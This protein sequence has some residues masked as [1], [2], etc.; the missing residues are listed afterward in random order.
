MIIR[1]PTS[2]KVVSTVGFLSTGTLSVAAFS[3]D[4]KTIAISGIS[5]IE[6]ADTVYVFDVATGNE[7]RSFK[8]YAGRVCALAFSPDGKRL[9]TGS[10]DSTA[11]VWDLSAKP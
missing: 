4:G 11:L 2:G 3:M 6:M 8:A 7:L 9:V 10:W 1:D 5:R